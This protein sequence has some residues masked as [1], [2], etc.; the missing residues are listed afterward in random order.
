MPLVAIRDLCFRY[1]DKAILDNVQMSLDAGEVV[2]LLGP[3]GCGKTTLLDCLIGYKKYNSGSIEI[4][5]QDDKTLSVAQR[6]RLLAYVPQT[7]SNVFPYTVLQMVLMGRTPH[8]GPAASPNGEDME[9]ARNALGNLGIG[10]FCERIYSSLSGGEQQ[11]VLIARSMAQDARIILLDEP[12]ASLDIKNE[13]M[14]LD[15][16]CELA[17][18]S[19]KAFI[20]ATHQPNHAFCFENKR[21]AIKTAL[22][23]DRHI[24]YFGVPSQVLNEQTIREVYNVNCRL[25]EFENGQK[26]IIVQ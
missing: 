9:I 17:K 10:G 1:G 19:N 16:I 13:S 2:M 8:L 18:T 6:A 22:F 4:E 15:K 7:S 5:G 21:I 23:L 11:L 26:T 25:Y 3:N 24:R 20:I 12:T 14:V